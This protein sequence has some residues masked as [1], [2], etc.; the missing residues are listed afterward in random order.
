MKVDVLNEQRQERIDISALEGV[1]QAL[2]E[3]ARAL[4]AE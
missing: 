4:V 3:L 2:D 1:H